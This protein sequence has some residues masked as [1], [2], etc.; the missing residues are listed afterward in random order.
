MNP[1]H[2]GFTHLS[3]RSSPA[4]LATTPAY[5]Q[6]VSRSMMS[7]E[8][9]RCESIVR[10]SFRRFGRLYGEAGFSEHL[11]QLM[12][13][14]PKP[15][16]VKPLPAMVKLAGGVVRSTGL[17]VMELTPRVSLTVSEVVPTRLKLLVPV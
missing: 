13:G 8:I 9:A 4:S 3:V 7:S 10:M 2:S 15:E 11:A 6:S 17:G 1:L 16:L 14:K 12:T 5:P